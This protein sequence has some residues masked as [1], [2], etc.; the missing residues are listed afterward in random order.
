LVKSD[1]DVIDN[2]RPDNAICILGNAVAVAV[3]VEDAAI[4]EN[5]E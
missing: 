1:F 3:A 5:A 4:L 2:P